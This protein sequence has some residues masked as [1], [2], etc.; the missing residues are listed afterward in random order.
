MLIQRKDFDTGSKRIERY[1]WLWLKFKTND[2]IFHPTF[3][4]IGQIMPKTMY[5]LRG[6]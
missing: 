5:N 3:N 1:R 6:D 2:S 4:F